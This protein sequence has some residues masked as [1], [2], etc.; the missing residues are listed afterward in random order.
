VTD[1]FDT[2]FEKLL[3]P[4]AIEQLKT[5]YFRRVSARYITR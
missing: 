2:C 4:E 5:R 3:A 1:S